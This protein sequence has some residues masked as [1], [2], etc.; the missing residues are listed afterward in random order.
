MKMMSKRIIAMMLAAVVTFTSSGM[1]VF[2]ESS[3]N[4][5]VVEVST[6]ET[7]TEE[8]AVE[9]ASSEETATEE[10]VVEETSNEEAVAEETTAEETAEEVTTEE[11]TV[12]EAT[13][14]VTTEETTVEETTEEV[15]T[16]ETV[17]A[18]GQDRV[19][20]GNIPANLKAEKEKIQK[21]AEE[22]GFIANGHRDVDFDVEVA[23]EIT[24]DDDSIPAVRAGVSIPSSYDARD[25]GQT[26]SVKNQ[27]PWGS[28]WSFQTIAIAESA[29]KKI[30]GAE[31]NLSE[32]HL[33]EFFYNDN[34]FNYSG[35]AGDRTIPLTDTKED[36]GGNG[37]FTT[38]GLA[39]W[40][41]VA[42]EATHSSMVYE[43]AAANG[44]I[45]IADSYAFTDT[46]HLENAYW[47]SSED[48]NSIKRAIMEYGAA[49]MS[50][51][52]D[53]WFDSYGNPYWDGDTVYYKSYYS[54][55]EGGAN[56][57]VT[58]VGWDDNFPREYFKNTYDNFYFYNQGEDYL[59]PEKNGAWLIKNSWGTE[60]GDAGYF[61]L[62]YED[63][64]LKNATVFAFDFDTADNYD[65]NYQYD[66]SSGVATYKS[67]GAAAVYTVDM[68]SNYQTLDAV[69]IGFASV[70]SAYT[71]KIYKDL[72]DLSNPTSGTL[73]TTQTGKS[74]FQGYYTIELNE[75]VA[76][77][78]GDTF[79]V[80]VETKGDVFVD[81]TY[82]NGNWI[83]FTTT[84]N[85]GDTFYKSGSSWKDASY[86]G[87]TM[88]VK[89]FTSN[90]ADIVENKVLDANMVA[91]IPAQ[92]YTEKAVQPEVEVICN[93]TT[94]IKGTDYT[95]VYNNNIDVGTATAVI[96][97]NGNYSGTVT[98]E[99]TIN[100]K[101]ITADMI[102]APNTVFTGVAYDSLVVK[103]GSVVMDISDYEVKYNKD[104]L[105]AGKYTATIAGINNYTG[106]A[107][108]TFT[109]D[110]TDIAATTVSLEA[111][112][113]EYDGT[114]K[115]PAAIVKIGE[116]VIAASN[117][118]VKYSANKNAGKV[119]ATISGKGSLTGKVTKEFTITS[120]AISEDGITVANGTYTGKAVQ[121]KVTV[122]DGTK[123]LALN[124]DYKL[125]YS[126]NVDASEAAQ[127][128][129]TGINNYQGS[130]AKTFAITPSV[131]KAASIKAELALNG[132]EKNVIA[133][134]GKITFA[135]NDFTYEIR[136]AGTETA[137]TE[138]AVGQ[139][140]D[141][142]I[143]LQGNYSGTNVVKNVECKT[144]M[145]ALT[146]AF[147]DVDETYTY[148]GKAQKPAVVVKNGETE[149]AKN[150]YTVTYIDNVNAGTAK[151][152]VKGKK[153]IAGTVELAFEIQPKDVT[154]GWT[155]K[156]IP[157]KVY[158]GKAQTPA[159]SVTGLKAKKDYTVTYTNNVDA[160]TAKATIKLTDNYKYNEVVGASVDTTFEIK[161]APIKSVKA[162]AAIYK[163]EG[164]AVSTI[165]T[166]K[167][168]S[169][170]LTKA[171][172]DVVYT[173]N[174]KVGK[175]SV[176]VKA[177]ADSNYE[178]EKTATFNITK[179]NL[180]TA[181]VTGLTD[182]TYTGSEVKHT[183]L[184]V[185]NKDG[186]LLT[187]G[188]DYTL[189]YSKNIKAGKASVKIVAV[190][191]SIYTGNKTVS[192]KVLPANISSILEVK[193]SL[194]S[195]EYTGKALTYKPQE[196]KGLFIEKTTGN[197]MV[198]S[199]YKITYKNNVNAG[200]AK[201]VLTGK[202]NYTGA[203]EVSFMITP[204]DIKALEI[205]IKG[206]AAYIDS[207]TAAVPEIRKFADG[208]YNLVLG[209]DY[210]IA[211]SGAKDKG[212]ARIIV[213][214]TG[215]YTGSRSFV[216][217]VK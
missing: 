198:S 209:K 77:Q 167:S 83:R 1:S 100:K 152:M 187:E 69:G 199:S 188:I 89:A 142:V 128:T 147:V 2:A 86:I 23:E 133:T 179:E 81:A 114:A 13:E 191:S 82:D 107:K 26:T 106:S 36:Q 41:G 211:C 62:S 123:K 136:N 183:N 115:K 11:T 30:K 165:L 103:N 197:E 57:A 39:R 67:N 140:Y 19:L 182:L 149:V 190:D 101:V 132:S 7:T 161:K 159:V 58:V 112:S 74:S 207:S 5:Q 14:E 163:G 24:S 113:V 175:A 124:K 119:T 202:G 181:T 84:E 206:T 45:N 208:K 38:W 110:K 146:V 138:V 215:N 99:F 28:C 157:A 117:Y 70:N 47:I 195:K 27:D 25:N 87:A 166:V 160:G 108:V 97:G 139:K 184:V 120:K 80:V 21:E 168:G 201:M 189:V 33:V 43:N 93:G 9:E 176:T 156:A 164:V 186:K 109:I 210:T 34:S 204:K 8:A 40:N 44:T 15:T 71:V 75:S 63:V 95:V 51:F 118:T 174:T 217:T 212:V 90:A 116:Q 20:S 68:G 154:A 10:T 3:Q 213:T 17:E 102:S 194:A 29:Y 54:Y 169:L 105:N 180:K 173:N 94:L 153:A 216:Y 88:R 203:V 64:S 53:S 111:E 6:E 22:K 59:L 72:T 121:P 49:G 98:K 192:F 91:D 78:K 16:E 205:N 104:P 48:K 151:V 85:A 214:G 129:V 141:I 200:T 66:G 127:V 37:V 12:E 92:T 185:K 31:A 61:W 143:T 55:G 73:M 32:A 60:Y 56:H 150:S 137:A 18:V 76:L 131:V 46:M 135:A 35:L 125:E 162:A 155:I 42:N 134:S 193:E 171:D 122:T 144:D 196:L 50:Y 130:V 177:K 172:Y 4:D 126:N 145:K 52:Y 79:A 170:V 96:T 65:N 158:N 178:S 148:N